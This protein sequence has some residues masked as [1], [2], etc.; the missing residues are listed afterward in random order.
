[1]VVTVIMQNSHCL[2]ILGFALTQSLRSD[3]TYITSSVH[4]CECIHSRAGGLRKTLSVMPLML[5]STDVLVKTS[6]RIPEHNKMPLAS[7]ATARSRTQQ[8][9]LSTCP[10]THLS[11]ADIGRRLLILL[12]PILPS[13]KASN[14]V[15][16]AFCVINGKPEKTRGR[17]V[18]A[19]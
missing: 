5:K 1:M 14:A 17:H 7:P 15:L 8:A 11:L 12:K 16:R 2:Q 19:K 4:I 10:H 6:L 13:Q 9:L 18:E 3:L